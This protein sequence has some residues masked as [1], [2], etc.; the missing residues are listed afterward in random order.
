[1]RKDDQNITDGHKLK[2][3][4]FKRWFHLEGHICGISMDIHKICW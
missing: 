4:N 2:I 1:M 3:Y